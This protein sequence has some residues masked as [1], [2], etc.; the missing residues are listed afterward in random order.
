[1]SD[2]N[3]LLFT[4]ILAEVVASSVEPTHISTPLRTTLRRSDVVRGRVNRID[5]ERHEV[6]LAPDGGSPN[7]SVQEAAGEIP[8]DHLV[9]AV[10]SV[11]NY[12]GIDNQILRNS[13]RLMPY[14]KDHNC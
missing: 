10:G 2:T 14:S 5:L 9:L 8:Y 11:S 4:P 12:L 13:A 6:L 3:A 1:V 7:D